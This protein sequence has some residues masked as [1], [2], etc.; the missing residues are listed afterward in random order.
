MRNGRVG[1]AIVGIPETPRRSEIAILSKPVQNRAAQAKVRLDVA[2]NDLSRSAAAARSGASA[3]AMA[4]SL[5]HSVEP[6]TH[7]QLA[8]LLP[9]ALDADPEK[10]CAPHKAIS[11]YSD[12]EAELNRR[13]S[14]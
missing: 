8:P 6:T 11:I 7:E 2:V 5:P 9:G 4:T 10:P 3:V 1:F 13:G 14:I 12:L